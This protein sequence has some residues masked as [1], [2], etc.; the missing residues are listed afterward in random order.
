MGKC[1]YKIKKHNG[2]YYFAL[3]PSNNHKQRIGQSKEYQTL[4]ECKTA[5]VSFRNFINDNKLDKA[6]SG[7]LHIN[8]KNENT[9]N[10]YYFKYIKNNEI[11]FFRTIGYGV[12]KSC[13]NGI[14]R[15]YEK[16]DEYTNNDLN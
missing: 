9:I 14:K 10:R 5:I 7:K 11:I 4:E 13:I 16:I 6:T 12:R 2:K 3:Y 15:I 1:G 8:S